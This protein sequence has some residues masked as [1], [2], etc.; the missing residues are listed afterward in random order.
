VNIVLDNLQMD[1]LKWLG[2]TA[3]PHR[4]GGIEFH[5]NKR[6]VGYIHPMTF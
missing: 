6:E 3:E 5:I 4:L 1:I 2:G